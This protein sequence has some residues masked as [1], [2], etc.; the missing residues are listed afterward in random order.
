MTPVSKGDDGAKICNQSING[1]TFLRLHLAHN[2]S[3]TLSPPPTP[4]W[5]PVKT[6]TP[7]KG[8]TRPRPFT[9]EQHQAA[10]ER[11]MMRPCR[12]PQVGEAPGAAARAPL[13]PNSGS[14]ATWKSG[15]PLDP[16]GPCHWDLLSFAAI[17]WSNMGTKA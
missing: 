4:Q 11:I 13:F 3:L 9:S 15:R 7:I 1:M 10:S 17:L 2:P 12:G 8:S 5:G 14:P 16:P 6:Q